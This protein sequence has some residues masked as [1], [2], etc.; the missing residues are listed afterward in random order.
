MASDTQELISC[1]EAHVH[2]TGFHLD[3][4]A[5]H[6]N[7]HAPRHGHR[8]DTGMSYFAS[9]GAKFMGF[10][11]SSCD[12]EEVATFPS[13]ETARNLEHKCLFTSYKWL[14][15]ISCLLP[16]T[17]CF[18]QMTDILV[19][20]KNLPEKRMSSFYLHLAG[21]RVSH[22]YHIHEMYTHTHTGALSRCKQ[23]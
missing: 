12:A 15:T 4:T 13:V 18:P 23:I 11:A 14:V 17:S 19:T 7:E 3:G 9:P 1:R 5:K 20:S 21:P 22:T 10:T 8:R 6:L 16:L 2:S